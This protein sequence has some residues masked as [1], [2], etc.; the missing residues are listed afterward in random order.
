MIEVKAKVDEEQNGTNITLSVE[1]TGKDILIET[2]SIIQALMG[3]LK[4]N[5]SALHLIAVKVIADNPS[6]LIG[7]AE[8]SISLPEVMEHV[9]I[10]EGVN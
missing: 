3:D 9:T 1:G 2:M 4:N 8:E 7:D 10:K 6:I 5:S